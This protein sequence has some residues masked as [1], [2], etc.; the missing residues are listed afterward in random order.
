LVGFIAFLLLLCPFKSIF[1]LSEHSKNRFELF[2]QLWPQQ[3]V[4]E[5]NLTQNISILRKALEETAYGKRFIATFHG[6]GY[7]FVEPVVMDKANPPALAIPESFER[8]DF[9]PDSGIPQSL[10]DL[11]PFSVRFSV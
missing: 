2:E 11:T 8:P 7:R 4:E 6:H 3:A 9:P 10:S 5:A 1:T